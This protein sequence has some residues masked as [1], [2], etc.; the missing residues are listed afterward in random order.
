ME[1]KERLNPFLLTAIKLL[2]LTSTYAPQY[3]KGTVWLLLLLGGDAI[4]P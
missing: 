4:F 2:L 3:L 1:K